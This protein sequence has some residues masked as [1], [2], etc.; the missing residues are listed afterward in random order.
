MKG[1]IKITA[2][3]YICLYEDHHIE[4]TI[5][6]IQNLHTK[7]R[8]YKVVEI[9][10]SKTEKITSLAALVLLS[11]LHYIQLYKKN[12]RSISLICDKSSIKESFFEK[13]YFKKAVEQGCYLDNDRTSIIFPFKT[14]NAQSIYECRGMLSDYINSFKRELAD[15]FKKYYTDEDIQKFFS[16]LLLT[17][18]ECLQNVNHHAYPIEINPYI[19]NDNKLL[20][21]VDLFKLKLF[22]CCLWYDDINYKI[23][24]T[25]YDMGIGVVNSYSDYSKN[26]PDS[27]KMRISKLTTMQIFKEAL[28]EG[29]SRMFGSGRGNGLNAILNTSMKLSDISLILFSDGI[30]FN[31]TFGGS[32]CKQFNNVFPGT[33]AEWNFKLAR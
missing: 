12:K 20:K 22:W 5:L 9:D 32:Y 7:S 29:C 16:D 25:I 26:R 31:R 24:F 19:P 17:I 10:F 14:Y 27:E 8:N 23:V 30:I 21:N 28:Q 13:S 33:A 6:F 2:P 1:K 3:V 18:T 4:N 11:H 15:V